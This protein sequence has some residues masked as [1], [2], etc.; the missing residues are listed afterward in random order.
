MDQQ[1]PLSRSDSESFHELPS[2]L[3]DK[4]D[5]GDDFDLF[6]PGP[7]LGFTD[8][9]TEN[10]AIILGNSA[11]GL[12]GEFG[13][14]PKSMDR[15]PF[16]KIK[17]FT[18]LE[19]I[20]EEESYELD[21]SKLT[22]KISSFNDFDKF[23]FRK[24]RKSAENMPDTL[25]DDLGKQKRNEINCQNAIKAINRSPELSA[26][27]TLCDQSRNLQIIDRRKTNEGSIKQI[28][29]GDGVIFQAHCESKTFYSPEAR[30]SKDSSD[31]F[32]LISKNSKV[33]E[34]LIKPFGDPELKEK[35]PEVKAASKSPRN[36]S[37]QRVNDNFGKPGYHKTEPSDTNQQSTINFF[38]NN[39][40]VININNN[41]STNLSLIKQRVNN[42]STKNIYV[43]ADRYPPNNA[44]SKKKNKAS[45]PPSDC[46]KNKG[47][48]FTKNATNQPKA[49]LISNARKDSKQ[50]TSERNLMA[51]ST[52]FDK[53][54]INTKTQK[55]LQTES[56]NGSTLLIKSEV[57][58]EYSN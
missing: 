8:S 30:L 36:E 3:K 4:L 31:Y 37:S 27:S 32:A 22:E 23:S 41:N 1:G 21:N 18:N 16:H 2:S 5:F 6:S 42:T 20:I 55:T 49:Q 56:E 33:L 43:G 58:A 29:D 7:H 26:V 14:E 54:I 13:L 38:Q 34:P 35:I 47:G 25:L 48:K 53:K 11:P 17:G 10:R 24:L 44:F 39:N 15:S 12:D 50:L 45:E 9:L 51:S 19:N 40:I 46:D 28:A 57:F 52:G